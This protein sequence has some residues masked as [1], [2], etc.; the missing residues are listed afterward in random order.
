MSIGGIL[1]ELSNCQGLWGQVG[2]LP[3]TESSPGSGWEL[4]TLAGVVR[5]LLS[6]QVGR[7]E[8]CL[9]QCSSI[10]VWSGEADIVEILGNVGYEL[11]T[12]IN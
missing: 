7:F 10:K 5:G 8:D 11:V 3:E 1:N 6:Q 9:Q 2:H 4:A 12:A